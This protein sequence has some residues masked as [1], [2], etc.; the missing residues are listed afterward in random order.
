M[1]KSPDSRLSA[2]NSALLASENFIV[3]V[4]LRSEAKTS[5]LALDAL[6]HAFE[7][8]K[9]FV[10][11]LV[12]TAPGIA[13]V[14][15]ESNVAPKMSRVE[16]LLHGKEFRFELTFALKCPV[17]KDRDFWG[18]IRLLSSVYDRLS[19]LASRFHERKGIELYLEEARLDQQKDDE[20]RSQAFRK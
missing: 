13:L 14:P 7:E 15:F 3:P 5:Q 16:M 20:D 1:F 2:S 9:G 12:S 18:R 8:V 4:T 11:K 19:E 10:T 6:T 17:P